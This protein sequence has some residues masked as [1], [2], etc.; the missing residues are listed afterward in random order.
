MTSLIPQI[1][2]H[3]QIANAILCLLMAAYLLSMASRRP[4]AKR[5]MAINCVLFA[6]QS[7]ALV[8]ILNAHAAWFLVSRPLFAMQLGPMLYLYFLCIHR[9]EDRLEAK[10]ALHFIGGLALFLLFVSVK[11]LRPLVG[12]AI[13]SS[14]LIY[15]LLIAKQLRK[16]KR[17]LAH[18]GS[19]AE[20]AFLWLKALLAIAIVNIMLELAVNVELAYG[21][22]LENSGSLLVASVAFLSINAS[23]VLAALRRSHYLEWMYQLASPIPKP[24]QDH[25]TSAVISVVDD[26]E[27]R[28]LFERWEKLVQTEQLHKLEFGI[29]LP[30]AARKLQVPA[31]QLS[32]AVNQ[33]Y[34]KS[35]SSYLNDLRIQE[36]QLLLRNR[37]EL[38]V[39]EVMHESG[40]SSKSNFNK[41]FLRVVGMSP[42]AFR[43]NT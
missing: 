1:I 11:S 33:I 31:R 5:L 2:S 22:A 7:L 34:R 25:A 36:A 39:I 21:V 38:S 35:F 3:L 9:E 6:H 40:F 12:P 41:E 20:S 17:E 30:Q 42:S 15:T 14:F 18:I 37:K 13:F 29:T 27:S 28:A 32:N 19:Y 16:S 10:D 24:E 43:E 23:M 4:L 26:A 8:G